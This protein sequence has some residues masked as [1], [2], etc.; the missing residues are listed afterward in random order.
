MSKKD[1]KEKKPKLSRKKIALTLFAILDAALKGYR[2]AMEEKRYTNHLRKAAKNL[3]GDIIDASEKMK[4]KLEKETRKK[5]KRNTGMVL[6]KNLKKHISQK[7]NKEKLTEVSN[8]SDQD[9]VEEED[10]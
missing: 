1:K 6:D 7:N 3:A 4:E 10:D 2:P 8:A 5:E 9:E